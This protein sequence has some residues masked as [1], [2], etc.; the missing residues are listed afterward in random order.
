MRN[1]RPNKLGG[2]AV[3][4]F[5]ILLGFCGPHAASNLDL[6][7]ARSRIVLRRALFLFFFFAQSDSVSC[8]LILLDCLTL[9]SSEHFK[10]LDSG[11]AGL[12][13]QRGVIRFF[14]DSWKMSFKS[15]SALWSCASPPTCPFSWG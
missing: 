14:V 5:H 1:G 15:L 13:T 11:C 2:A 8:W 6:L 3:V 7:G 10:F 12:L 9:S 4:G